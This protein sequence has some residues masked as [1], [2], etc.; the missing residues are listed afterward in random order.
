MVEKL[1]MHSPDLVAG[2]IEKIAELFPNCVIEASGADGQVTHKI[3]FDLL[4]QELSDEIVE[5]PLERY[6]LNWP[7]KREAILAANAPIAKT[8]RPCREE[9]IDFDSTQNLFIEGD[10]LEALKL[11]QETYLGKVKMIYIDPPYNTGRDFVYNDSFATDNRTY[12]QRSLQTNEEGE[13][14]VLNTESN[15][16]FHSDWL[17]MM[18][19][20]LRVAYRLLKDEGVLMI[21]ID[22]NEIYNLWTACNE[23]FGRENFVECFAYQKKAAAKGVP[24]A[25]MVVSVH[26]Y[27]LCYQK[28]AKF[29]F[30]GIE[31]SE[32]SFSNP[33]DDPRGPWRNT[34]CKSTTKDATEAFDVEDPDTG[35]IFRDTWAHSD[36]EMKRLANER[37]LIFPASADG[38]VRKKEYLNEFA[39]PNTPVKS[40]L[41][42]YDAQE[43][44]QTLE[45]LMGGK[46]FQN[47]KSLKLMCDIIRFTVAEDELVLD[48]F[49]GSGTTIHAVHEINAEDSG[50]RRW[51]AVQ[52]PEICDPKSNA[53]ALG[54]STIA[55]IAKERIRRATKQIAVEQNL[56][57]QDRDLGFRVLKIASSN[58]KDVYYSP[59]D[60]SQAMLGGLVDNIKPDRLGEDLLFQVL[61]D[62]GVDL[63]LP[64][65]SEVR[66]GREVYF[67]N[68][69]PHAS[70][71]LIACFAADVPESLVKT[72]AARQPLRAVF[73]DHCFN[74]DA[75][76]I[77][78]EQI[79]KQ[80]SPQT[81]LKSL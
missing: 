40:W 19:A 79:F 50:N 75:A 39:N 22:E 64:I 49:A 31:R 68:D 80:M 58:M 10:N 61:L 70:P 81:Q 41:G 36:G 44:T 21:S 20:R 74:A 12:A 1:K 15:G 33:D 27:I 78:V 51:I 43:N 63:G 65:R 11:L 53:F 55:D 38:Q 29:S 48:F 18:V 60:T 35:R 54:F 59:A 23:L 5:G 47:P 3:D 7:G 69:S 42:L 25:N 71:D 46:V 57:A 67:V 52:V 28:S 32:D 24:P 2:N 17:S 62:C 8:L 77:N 4:R 9:S 45:K 72:I 13:R 66:D 56:L 37:V 16:R 6:H 76:K 30:R 26:E 14:L 34:N 73:R